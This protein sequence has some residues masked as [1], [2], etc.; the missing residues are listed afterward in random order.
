[1]RLFASSPG[2]VV[3]SIRSLVTPVQSSDGRPLGEDAW[4]S[5][6][7]ALPAMEDYANPMF[8]AQGDTR[9]GDNGMI[10]DQ[11]QAESLGYG[12]QQQNGFH[13]GERL[14]HTSARSRAKWE[15]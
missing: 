12:C 10:G 1:M 13:H 11:R 9:H 6:K 5:I 3:S 14:A 8:W 4:H 15:I 7:R 2:C